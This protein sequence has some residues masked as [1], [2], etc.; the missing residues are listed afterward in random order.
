MLPC[1][2]GYVMEKSKAYRQILTAG[3]LACFASGI[4]FVCMLFGHNFWPLIISF[5]LLGCRC[6]HTVVQYIYNI[7]FLS[8]LGSSVLPLLPVMMENCA[9][10]TYPVSEDVAMGL[11]FTGQIPDNS[12]ISLKTSSLLCVV[13]AAILLAW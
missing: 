13:Q 7:C 6:I 11:M 10:V 1:T 3:L 2:V 4:F 12:S 5:A 9:E 8:K